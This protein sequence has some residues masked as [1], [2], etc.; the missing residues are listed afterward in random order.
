MFTCNF[1]LL[2]F[3]IS[4]VANTWSY[5]L[6]IR[7]LALACCLAATFQNMPLTSFTEIPSCCFKSPLVHHHRV[8]VDSLVVEAQLPALL[9]LLTGPLYHWCRS[10]F[11]FLLFFCPDQHWVLE[12]WT[13]SKNIYGLSVNEYLRVTSAGLSVWSNLKEPDRDEQNCLNWIK[14]NGRQ[15]KKLQFEN[16]HGQIWNSAAEQQALSLCNLENWWQRSIRVAWRGL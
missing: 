6:R 14:L 2:L 4:A 1:L 5:F 15:R 12:A 16:E 10:C 13:G 8:F 9:S 7:Q 11:F 3:Q